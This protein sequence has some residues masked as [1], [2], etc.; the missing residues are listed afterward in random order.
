MRAIEKKALERAKIKSEH[1][2]LLE[3]QGE[4]GLLSAREGAP[5][6]ERR[7]NHE[8]RD[9]KQKSGEA[10]REDSIEIGVMGM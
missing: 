1:P 7:L 4:R 2:G 9:K 10:H 5:D 6:V 8:S 3:H